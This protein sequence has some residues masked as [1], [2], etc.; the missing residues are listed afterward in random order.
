M[1][2]STRIRTVFFCFLL[3]IMALAIGCSGF[4]RRPMDKRYYDLDVDLAQRSGADVGI[5]DP[6]IV[7]ELDMAPVFDSHQFIY[8][9]HADEYMND[10]YNEFVSY[11]A[12]LIT[13][14]IS[15]RLYATAA[16]SRPRTTLRDK[17]RFRL[18][19]RINQLYGDYRVKED[20]RAV[21]E[22]LLTFEENKNN[23]YQV[24]L[25]KVF[26]QSFSIDSTEPP[27]LSDGWSRGLSAII[28]AF[29]KDLNL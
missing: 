28:E 13:E 12:K 29:L 8:R 23:Q 16:F 22:I 6:L 14:K 27:H 5:G 15:Q 19:G 24:I 1:K 2:S 11:P 18:S 10:Y 25:T 26:K 17:I 9:I 4:N 21:L 20:P 7:R 3:A